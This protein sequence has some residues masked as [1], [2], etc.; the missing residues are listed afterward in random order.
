MGFEDATYETVKV[1][2]SMIIGPAQRQRIK[3]KRYSQ[4][5]LFLPTLAFNSASVELVHS[6]VESSADKIHLTRISHDCGKEQS[7]EVI[8][9]KLITL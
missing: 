4:C 1:I 5:N 8:N 9:S 2:C 6:A 7:C 3:W